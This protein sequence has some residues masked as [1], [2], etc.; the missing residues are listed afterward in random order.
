MAGGALG[1]LF[2]F[3]SAQALT[4]FLTGRALDVSPD[5]RVLGFTAAV[6]ILTGLLFG[7][8]PAIQATR[9]DLTPALKNDAAAGA[10]GRPMGLGNLLVAGQVA[11]SLLLLIGAGLFIRT[12]GNLKNLDAGFHADRV[13]LVS[14]NPGLSRYTPERTRNFYGQLLERVSALPGV[15]SASVADA[16]LL[17]GRYVE[18]LSAEGHQPGAADADDVSIREVTP[19]FFET[20]GIA[21][22]MG[23]DFSPLDRS[24]APKV[25]IVNETIARRYFDGRNP[26]GKHVGLGAAPD[27]E[28]IGVAADTKYNGLRAPVPNTL[29][30]PIDQFPPGPART[31]HVRTSAEPARLAAAVREQVRAIDPNLPV[32]MRPFSELVDAN[33]VQ[34]RLIATLSGFFGGLALLLASIGLY[35]VMAYNVE[36]RTREIG[37]RMSLGAGRRDVLW[38]VL[39]NC[40]AMV[41][42][43][44]AIGVPATVWLSR[45]IARQLFGIAPG[46]PATIAAAAVT[47]TLVGALA[48]YLPARRAANVDPMV[49]LRYE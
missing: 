29:Y 17:G 14:L 41:A 9:P 22:R 1:L 44:V 46:D 34:E 3:W 38:M 20:M 15:R 12:L 31:L 19:R 25:A 11:L 43:G 30:V 21:L 23:R 18:G 40:L 49:A 24:G 2:A 36:R 35:G 10:Q 4:G 39:R 13:L 45:L 7:A 42:A 27:M 5:A 8:M 6:S 32:K 47:M 37:I 48:G 26:I 16:P 28:I 33:L